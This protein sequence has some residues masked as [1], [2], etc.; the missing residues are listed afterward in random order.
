MLYTKIQLNKDLENLS[1]NTLIIPDTYDE[2]EHE[3][4]ANKK[5]LPEYIILPDNIESLPINCFYNSNVKN[6]K[7]PNSL[8]YINEGA[9][10]SCVHLEN[11]KL[12]ENIISIRQAAF[13]NTLLKNIE[14]PDKI[15]TISRGLFSDCKELEYIKLPKELEYV[16]KYAFETCRSLKILDFKNTKLKN[17]ETD[18]ICF[19]TNLEK[20]FFPKALEKIKSDFI[21]M[22]A[23]DIYI[24]KNTIIINTS[25]TLKAFIFYEEQ[26]DK[27]LEKN[28]TFKEINDYFL[29][30]IK[31]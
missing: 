18:S 26:L 6:I 28:M 9:F 12:P 17:I 22:S 14:L 7:L 31:E 21:K 16:Q 8:K 30:E 25:F 11:I 19:C 1:G 13:S 23:P 3:C 20:V 15:K 2:I 4:F 24:S 10:H 27:L 5:S 29:E